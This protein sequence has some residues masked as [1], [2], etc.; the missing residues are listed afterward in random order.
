M[1]GVAQ[2]ES[3]KIYRIVFHLASNTLFHLFALL[4][5][6]ED[7]GMSGEREMCEFGVCYVVE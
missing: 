4:N 7:C 5:K 2:V 6:N 1:F 3:R